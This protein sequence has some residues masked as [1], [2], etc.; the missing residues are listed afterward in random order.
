[1]DGFGGILAVVLPF[2]LF[3]GSIGAVIGAQKKAAIKGAIL[4]AGLGPI[5]WLIAFFAEGRPQ[6]PYC[7]TRVDAKFPLCPGCHSKIR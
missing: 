3:F 7:G 5:G 6:C 1:M 4:G 2:W